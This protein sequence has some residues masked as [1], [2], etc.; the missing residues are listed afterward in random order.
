[1]CAQERVGH[2]ASRIGRDASI[3]AEDRR[4][5][6]CVRRV[7]SQSPSSSPVD[8]RLAAVDR[9]RLVRQP[10]VRLMQDRCG[11][12]PQRGFRGC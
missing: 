5:K 12:D 7:P 6:P 8:Q 4:L 11:R 10:A 1:M 9:V 2:G 3:A